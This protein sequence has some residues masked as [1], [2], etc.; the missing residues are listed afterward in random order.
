MD[1]PGLE[2]EALA[3]PFVFN[4]HALVVPDNV[5][6]GAKVPV[7]SFQHKGGVELVWVA[8]DSITV[9]A[10]SAGH[11]VITLPVKY[12]LLQLPLQI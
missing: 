5:L 3:N 9:G 10:T 12:V 6:E 11:S 8:K 1:A 4:S 7:A 2:L